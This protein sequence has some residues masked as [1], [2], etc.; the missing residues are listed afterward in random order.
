M[1]VVLMRVW[2]GG[3]FKKKHYLHNKFCQNCAW[4]VQAALGA[5]N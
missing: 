1:D 3:I 5:P 2:Q 4:K